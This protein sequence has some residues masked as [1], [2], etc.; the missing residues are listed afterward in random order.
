MHW[1]CSVCN[2][3]WDGDAPPEKCP[4]CGAPAEKYAE[5]T[6][7]QWGLVERSR[8]TNAIHVKLLTI[9]PELQK[10]ARDGIADNLDARCVA[11]FERL[12]S[13]ATFL[14][15]SILAELNGHMMRGK[16]G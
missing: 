9:L 5:L 6:P 11:A 2:F 7:E 13:D 12:L 10:M 4:K 1:K 15:K 16:W 3:I 14:E 8:H